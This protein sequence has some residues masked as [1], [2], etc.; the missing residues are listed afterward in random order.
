[1]NKLFIC[2]EIQQDISF[3][4]DTDNK[5]ILI[6]FVK[7]SFYYEIYKESANMVWVRIKHSS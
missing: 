5:I 4:N 7:I 3:C 2:T 6:V 1:M